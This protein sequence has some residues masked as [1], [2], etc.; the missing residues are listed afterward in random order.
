MKEEK[1]GIV[2]IISMEVSKSGW[3]NISSEE[4]KR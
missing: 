4:P 3:V 2:I 1:N